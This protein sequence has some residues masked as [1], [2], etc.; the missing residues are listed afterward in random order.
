MKRV[1]ALAL[2]L[3][4]WPASGERV[5]PLFKLWGPDQPGCAAGV[6][7][8]AKLVFARGYGLASLE[9]QV[10]ITPATAFYAGSLSKQFTAASIL[11]LAKR[12]L[13]DIDAPARKYVP[14]LPEF[15]EGDPTVRHLLHHVSGLRESYTL[16]DLAG[17]RN[18][19]DVSTEDDVMAIVRRMKGLNFAPGS[20]YLYSN[21]G[22]ILLA[23]IVK[24][25]SG[26]GLRNFARESIFAPLG[27]R[28]TWFRDDHYE[29][30]PRMAM[31]Y[32]TSVKGFRQAP[33]HVDTVGGGGLVTTVEDLARWDAALS[34]EFAGIY[35]EM[36]RPFKLSGGAEI[37]Y[38]RGLIEG[39]YRGLK[40]VRHGGSLAGYRSHLL[41]FPD[42]ELTVIALCNRVTDADSLAQRIAE[43]F[44]PADLPAVT[45]R[46][47]PE[48]LR[49]AVREQHVGPFEGRYKNEE[50]GVT[51]VFEKRGRNS[52]VMLRPRNREQWLTQIAENRFSAKDFGFFD[53]DA[54]GF[55]FSGSGVLNLRF[56]RQ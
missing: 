25:V 26:E 37:P 13:I 49:S 48:V 36:L 1:A 8:K 22:Y 51:F 32:S 20:R 34:G 16:L 6:V 47:F 18:G 56:S 29:V 38:R 35:A 14:E 2:L 10:P 44:L 12:E 21:T 19:D 3:S 45:E 50:L 55:R 17:W 52:L 33:A 23:R 41:R 43:V 31:G 46:L 53:F 28:N 11:L 15:E 30:V 24:K 54:S 27:M 5:D 39:E 4:R 40:T 7:E 42:Q 9:H